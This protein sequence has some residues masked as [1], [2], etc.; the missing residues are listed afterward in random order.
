MHLP[1]IFILG[2]WR[3]KAWLSAELDRDQKTRGLPLCTPTPLPPLPLLANVWFQNRPLENTLLN[4]GFYL[5]LHVFYYFVL[6]HHLLRGSGCFASSCCLFSPLLFMWGRMAEGGSSRA[7]HQQ[8]QGTGR[9]AQH[10]TGCLR[11]N[12]RGKSQS[13][14]GI[15]RGKQKTMHFFFVWVWFSVVSLSGKKKY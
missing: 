2:H 11:W 12:F 15:V 3:S 8:T 6:C 5:P 7:H 14:T 1:W 13:E 4:C 10:H 9:S